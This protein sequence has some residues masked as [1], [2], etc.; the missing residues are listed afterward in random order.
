MSVRGSRFLPD[1]ELQFV[2]IDYL[3][4]VCALGDDPQETRLLRHCVSTTHDR[5]ED[6]RT[7]FAGA[8]ATDDGFVPEHPDRP[9]SPVSHFRHKM[10]CP[11]CEQTPEYLMERFEAALRAVYEPGRRAVIPFKI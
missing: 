1:E 5:F 11:R 2:A 8:T 6:E 9:Y 3:C 4:R 7:W 10:L